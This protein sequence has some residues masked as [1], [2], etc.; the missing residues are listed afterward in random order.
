MGLLRIKFTF[1]WVKSI[2][3]VDFPNSRSMNFGIGSRG[4]R[5]EMSGA[6]LYFPT[7]E[8]RRDTLKTKPL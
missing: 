7:P 8:T 5:D 2:D 3:L 4:K 6:L 1:Y